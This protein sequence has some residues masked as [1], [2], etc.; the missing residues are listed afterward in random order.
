MAQCNRCGTQLSN[1]TSRSLKVHHRHC[2]KNVPMK[3]KEP[4]S[5]VPK[6]ISDVG[7]VDE[8]KVIIAFYLF[9]AA[10][11]RNVTQ[12]FE[13]IPELAQ[14][15]DLDMDLDVDPM[16]LDDAQFVEGSSVRR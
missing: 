8:L 13:T 16:P 3:F 7:Q 11:S 12:N 5:R 15:M 4:T 14:E 2:P 9:T 6:L 1:K 10:H